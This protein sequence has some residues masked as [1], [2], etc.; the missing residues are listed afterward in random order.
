MLLALLVLI[1]FLC[2][3]YYGYQWLA[4]KQRTL[5]LSVRQLQADQKEAEFDL[6]EQPQWMQRKAWIQE[7]EPVMG[8][9]GDTKAQVL[10]F[11]SDGARDNKLEIEDQSLGN[12]EHGPAGARVSVTLKIKGSNEGL[13]RWLADLQKPGSFYAVSI[14][15]MQAD[16]DQKSMQCSVQISR[17]FKGS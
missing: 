5:E 10:K 2:A 12:V 17:Y 8:E 4:Q 16:E 11:V 14:T 7:H 1:A 6:Q 3:N 13:V 9:E 15:S